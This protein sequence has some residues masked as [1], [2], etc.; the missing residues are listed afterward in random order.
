MQFTLFKFSPKIYKRSQKLHK[1]VTV[2]EDAF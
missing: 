2:L 1:N